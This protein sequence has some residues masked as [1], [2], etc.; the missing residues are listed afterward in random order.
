MKSEYNILN[1]GCTTLWGASRGY[2]GL[3]GVPSSRTGPTI[4]QGSEAL[5]CHDQGMP[6]LCGKSVRRFGA[7][8]SV[9]FGTPRSESSTANCAYRITGGGV[10]N[11][12]H[13]EVR[14]QNELGVSHGA[15]TGVVSRC[16]K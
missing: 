14:R 11:L 7:T 10:P 8:R 1:E 6:F 12:S 2:W 15:A 13:Q 3:V 16:G 4:G 5:A 9:P